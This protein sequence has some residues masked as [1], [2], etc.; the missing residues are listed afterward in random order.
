[1]EQ[2]P[3]GGTTIQEQIRKKKISDFITEFKALQEK[4]GVFVSGV[5]NFSPYGILPSITYQTKEELDQ[6]E[7][8]LFNQPP[9]KPTAEE[10]PQKTAN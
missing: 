4:H 7:Q 3:N 6:I 8:S 5:I 10:T 2:K 9:V 1:M